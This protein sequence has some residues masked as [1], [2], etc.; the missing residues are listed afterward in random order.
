[1]RAVL[2]WSV[3][4]LILG[5]TWMFVAAGVFQ[6]G[7]GA[8]PKAFDKNVNKALRD[9]INHGAD[10]FN[11]QGDYAGCYRVFQGALIGIKPLLGHRPDLQKEIEDGLGQAE[12]LPRVVD[13]AFALRKVIDSVRSKVLGTAPPV[14]A[15]DKKSDDKKPDDKPPPVTDAQK[16]SKPPALDKKPAVKLTLW[17]WLGGETNVRKIVDDFVKNA[18]PDPKVNVTRD[19]K[20]KLDDKGIDHLKQLMVEYISSI[21]AGPLRYTGK[22][23][24]EAHRGLGITDAEFDAGG[25][26]F[27]KALEKNGVKQDD[28]NFIMQ[29][30]NETRKDI[31]EVPSAKDKSGDKKPDSDKKPE[32]AKD[33]DKAPVDK[34]KKADGKPALDKDKKADDKKPEPAKDKDK[35]PADKDKS[36]SNVPPARSI[37]IRGWAGSLPAWQAASL[38][39]RRL[40]RDAGA[41]A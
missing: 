29:K 40:A 10:L 25:A 19:G 35:A 4:G 14:V 13:R 3:V 39:R 17:D 1:M 15:R 12:R 6:A 9:V 34:D 16:P 27:K 20:I 38:D 18:A 33:K 28:V 23:M 30:L 37:S 5:L 21:S 31:V 36:A 22:S 11:L 24:K 7:A 26:H 32:P 8:D 2:R 41:W